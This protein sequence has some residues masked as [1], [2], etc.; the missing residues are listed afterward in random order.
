MLKEIE[1]RIIY[2]ESNEV[3]KL[4][5]TL[6]NEEDIKTFDLTLKVALWE[7]NRLRSFCRKVNGKK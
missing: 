3:K 7:L 4:K 6:L 2:L 5:E 1:K